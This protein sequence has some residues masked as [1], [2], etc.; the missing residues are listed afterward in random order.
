MH[1]IFENILIMIL[2]IVILMTGAY[3]FLLLLGW[4]LKLKSGN[5]E[6]EGL[7][8]LWIANQTEAPGN[9]PENE[10]QKEP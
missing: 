5:R 8:D 3:L 7:M 10:P 4:G 2:T 1:E 9:K 6:Q